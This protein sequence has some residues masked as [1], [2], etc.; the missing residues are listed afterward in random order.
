MPRSPSTL[1]S[2]LTQR[3]WTRKEALAV[4]EAHKASSLT[5]AAFAAQHGIQAQRIYGWM[6]QSSP[7]PAACLAR[8]AK[9][10]FVE[11]APCGRSAISSSARYELCI[12][13]GGSL[14]VEGPVDVASV[15]ALLA[16]LR[17]AHEC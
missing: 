15:R 7:Q 10:A 16:L 17:E 11:V 14:R 13:S 5:V 3:R 6:R 9:P 2:I 8:A 4:L 1:E 12:D